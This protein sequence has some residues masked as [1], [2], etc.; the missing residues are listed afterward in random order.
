MEEAELKM[1]KR[2]RPFK[3]PIGTRVREV[4]VVLDP[5]VVRDWQRSREATSPKVKRNKMPTPEKKDQSDGDIMLRKKA[6]DLKDLGN[7]HFSEFKKREKLM[8]YERKK[9]VLNWAIQCY[10]T[11]YTMCKEA[12]K[13]KARGHADTAEIVILPREDVVDLMKSLAKNAAVMYM[14]LAKVETVPGTKLHC[15]MKSAEVSW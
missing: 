14:Y 4:K 12:L 13:D 1:P 10:E 7:Q 11:G 9:A 8:T 2:K 3:V 6:Q 5:F 15:F